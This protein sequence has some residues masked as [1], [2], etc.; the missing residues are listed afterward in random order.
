MTPPRAVV[1]NSINQIIERDLRTILRCQTSKTVLTVA[2]AQVAADAHND[3]W[4]PRKPFHDAH[5]REQP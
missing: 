4:K 2:T 5:S 3:I 1:G